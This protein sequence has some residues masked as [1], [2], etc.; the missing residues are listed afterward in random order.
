MWDLLAAGI[1]ATGKETIIKHPSLLLMSASIIV[2]VVGIV[3]FLYI[4]CCT[5]H[6]TLVISCCC[7]FRSCC[8]FNSCLLLL[9]LLFWKREDEGVVVSKWSVSHTDR[10]FQGHLSWGFQQNVQEV[11]SSKT[12][13]SKLDDLALISKDELLI[14]GC[15]LKGGQAGRSLTGTCWSLFHILL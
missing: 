11:N 7:P 9:L 4:L 6:S 13:F 10:K 1:D 2:V 14:R 12:F 15:W 3:V 8:F 5:R